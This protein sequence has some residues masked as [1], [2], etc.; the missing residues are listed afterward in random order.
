M[1]I[2]EGVSYF[3]SF[4]FR[5]ST[6]ASRLSAFLLVVN[7]MSTLLLSTV[8]WIQLS[9]LSL[10]LGL[11]CRDRGSDRT[12]VGVSAINVSVQP[13]FITYC[14]YVSSQGMILWR[15]TPGV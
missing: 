14:R 4:D 7:N 5:V 13:V 10:G 9:C 15:D 11:A 3:R 1:Y 12:Y 6:L 8:V 2:Y